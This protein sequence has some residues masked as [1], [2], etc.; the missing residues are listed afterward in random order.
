MSN[1]GYV[2]TE[3]LYTLQKCSFRMLTQKI[4]PAHIM[5]QIQVKVEMVTIDLKLDILRFTF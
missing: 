2:L 1:L 4:T 3:L 5:V